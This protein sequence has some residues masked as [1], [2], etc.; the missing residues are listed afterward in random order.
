[1]RSQTQLR[2]LQD[3]PILITCTSIAANMLC[4]GS[5]G[6]VTKRK[7]GSR[8]IFCRA[9]EEIGLQAVER[10]ICRGQPYC[11]WWGGPYVPRPWNL[12]GPDDQRNDD[13][14]LQP[15]IS[16]ELDP[17]PALN[18]GNIIAVRRNKRVS[19]GVQSFPE[20]IQRAILVDPAA[21]HMTTVRGNCAKR[22][23]RVSTLT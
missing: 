17:R 15:Q 22:E 12:S 18:G 6:A 21:V 2:T 8:I 20:N 7:N 3:T 10:L 11:L 1:M 14:H 4:Q 19:L 9:L 16:V 5:T 13:V 23:S